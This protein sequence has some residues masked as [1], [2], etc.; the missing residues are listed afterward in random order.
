MVSNKDWR[1][2]FEQ[3]AQKS[4][5]NSQFQVDQILEA[6]KGAETVNCSSTGRPA[7][8]VSVQSMSDWA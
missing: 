1:Y 2:E 4:M 5:S 8:I 3:W 7:F 6:M